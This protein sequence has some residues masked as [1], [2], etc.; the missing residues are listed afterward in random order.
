M[1]ELSEVLE[2]IMADNH[3]DPT[4]T[5]SLHFI[6]NRCG[7]TYQTVKNAHDG[8]SVNAKFIMSLIERFNLKDNPRILRRLLLAFLKVQFP[9][10]KSTELFEAASI[11]DD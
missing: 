11:I 10:D 4:D 5:S 6:A 9:P 1:F 3:K 2:Q 7:V 8:K